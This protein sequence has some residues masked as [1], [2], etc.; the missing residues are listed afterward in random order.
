MYLCSCS[1]Y[2]LLLIYQFCIYI[3][4]PTW[5]CILSVHVITKFRIHNSKQ[6]KLNS[7]SRSLDSDYPWWSN[8]SQSGWGSFWDTGSVMFLQ[9]GAG[10]GLYLWI[11][12]FFY[13]YLIMKLN[14][15]KNYFY[16]KPLL[17]SLI[18]NQSVSMFST[19]VRNKRVFSFFLLFCQS[20]GQYKIYLSR[21]A[22]NIIF[23]IKT[24]YEIQ[25]ELILGWH[26]NMGCQFDPGKCLG[27]WASIHLNNY[28]HAQG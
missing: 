28:R 10:Y 23:Y 24:S 4:T 11:V 22:R 19:L 20:L 25:S 8:N 14:V 6:A 15:L 3:V 17:G 26:K 18:E 21:Y 27:L 1:F 9:L 5:M 16:L 7:S 12:Y 2:F 13:T